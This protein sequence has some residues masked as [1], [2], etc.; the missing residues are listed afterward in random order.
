MDF[1]NEFKDYMLADKDIINHRISL[2]KKCPYLM[3]HTRC[4]KCGCFMNVKAR[5]GFSKCPEG[6]W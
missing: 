5:L 1:F 2:C 3:K 4:E 6:K